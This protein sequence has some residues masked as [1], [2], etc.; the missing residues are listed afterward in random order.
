MTPL[1]SWNGVREI[2]DPWVGVPNVA[3]AGDAVTHEL[4]KCSVDDGIGCRVVEASQGKRDANMAV[5]KTE[6]HCIP[7]RSFR[8]APVGIATFDLGPT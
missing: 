7:V 8:L 3:N 6:Q 1:A 2:Y 5:D 4:L